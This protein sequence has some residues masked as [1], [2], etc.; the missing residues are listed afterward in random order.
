MNKMKKLFA[1]IL[2]IAM[3]L[4]M[5]AVLSA[6]KDQENTDATGGGEAGSYTVSVKSQGGLP[7]E[8]VAVSVY[9]DDTLS[10]LKGYDETDENGEAT[11]ELGGGSNF[12][13]T[14]SGVPAGYAVEESYSMSGTSTEIVLT[15]SLITGENLAD[16]TLGLGD[17]MYDFTVTTP[18]GTDVT[19]SEVLKEKKM[20]LL[21]FWYTTCSWCVTEFPF[22]EE[23]YQMYKDD[24][25]IIA[26]DPFPTD[27]AEA[28]AA[29]PAS[30]NLSLSF[31]LAACPT[32]WSNTF[33]IQGYPTS[34]IIDRYGVICLVE[35]GAITSLRPFTSLF[36]TFTADD[37][38]Q[39]LYQNVGELITNVKPTYEMDTSENI[40]ALIN[41]GELPITYR[42]EE[43]DS[44]EY[45]WPFIAAEKNGEQC[46]KASNQQI[47]ESFAIIY[48][49]V[50]LKAGQAF[51]FD[52]LRSTESAGDVLY[53]IVDG[54]DINSI[55]G[56]PDPEKWETTYPV[57]AEKDGEYEVALCYMKD[58]ST[59]VGDDTV[60]IKNV[61]IID[62]A[63]IEVPNY[64]PRQA[65]T[66]EDGFEFTYA[67]L[68]Y[69][70]ADGY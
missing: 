65:A 17:V 46:L 70:S 33:G 59:D 58:S 41:N 66:S 10:D 29:F 51:G 7:L 67:D 52:F 39:K 18:D 42:A 37:Y 50:T 27:S 43:G 11:M 31:P 12:T 19:L 20:V 8:K 13:I 61:R 34:V 69:N 1:V 54:D 16:T 68:V 14:L 23:A 35:S 25:G 62:A 55:S 44:A 53:V 4:S 48:A 2:T 26:V 6:C 63:D 56:A 24:V 64:I 47:E 38:E 60:Y 3:V 40:A 5:C 45:A 36:E 30:Y 49:D 32:T 15:S 9:A 22:M 28:I 21:N 57:V